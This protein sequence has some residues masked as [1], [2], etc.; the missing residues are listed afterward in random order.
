V[1]SDAQKQLFARQILLAELGFAGQE[2]LCAASGVLPSPADA[3]YQAVAR[4]Y[5][6]RAGV[7]VHA[8]ALDLQPGPDALR[9]PSA[10]QAEVAEL[11]GDPLLEGCAA[12]LLG[13]LAAVDAIKQALGA[14]KQT[15][16]R[17]AF[18]LAAEAR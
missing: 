3:R 12:W 8:D 18:V 13:S 7:T 9:L 11:A 5:L 2:R 1:L 14:G 10:T 4:E 6:E 15:S 16:C 17:P